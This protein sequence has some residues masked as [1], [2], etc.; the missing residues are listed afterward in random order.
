MQTNGISQIGIIMWKEKMLKYTVGLC[1]HGMYTRVCI[2]G[3]EGAG[4]CAL[5]SDSVEPEQAPWLGMF[6]CLFETGLF[7]LPRAVYA[8]SL[9]LAFSKF[10][11][12]PQIQVLVWRRDLMC[13]LLNVAF[14]SAPSSTSW[15]QGKTSHGVMSLALSWRE[16]GRQFRVTFW[17]FYCEE[18]ALPAFHA[19]EETFPH[20]V[21]WV[22]TM[23]PY[24]WEAPLRP[25]F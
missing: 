18:Q 4:L 20:L 8:V 5:H 19:T 12:Y 24:F 17:G 23:L 1:R 9:H 15:T 25:T 11:H 6:A 3:G 10:L 7:W 2:L 21:Q 13:F 16:G 22:C 14:V